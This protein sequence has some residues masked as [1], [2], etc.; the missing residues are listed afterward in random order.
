MNQMITYN[1]I[2]NLYADMKGIPKY[3]IYVIYYVNIKLSLP[4]ALYIFYI[5][6]FQFII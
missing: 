6:Y 4:N 5:Q 1:Y 2:H 3:Y